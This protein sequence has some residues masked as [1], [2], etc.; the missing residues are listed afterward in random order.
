METKTYETS[1]YGLAAFLVFRKMTLLGA[2]G[3]KNSP[4]FK[5]IFVD[6]DDRQDYVDEWNELDNEVSLTAKRY[7]WSMGVVKRS[8]QEVEMVDG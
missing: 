6:N 4:R 5:F 2:V 8:I 7:F 3:T 1:D